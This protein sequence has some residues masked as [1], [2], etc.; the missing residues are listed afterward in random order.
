MIHDHPVD[1][2]D[3]IEV[4][5]LLFVGPAQVLRPTGTDNDPR[6]GRTYA[7]IAEAVAECPAGDAV[8]APVRRDVIVLDLDGCGDKLAA[9]IENEMVRMGGTVP[10]MARS[11]SPG[12]W[13][14]IAAF[15]K[16]E[17]TESVR[18]QLRSWAQWFNRDPLAYGGVD[19]PAARVEFK[20]RLRLP[21][22]PSFKADCHQVRPCDPASVVVEHLQRVGLPLAPPATAAPA[23]NH[24]VEADDL[25]GNRYPRPPR[26]DLAP[27]ELHWWRRAMSGADNGERSDIAAHLA[28]TLA[29]AGWAD[30]EAL[31][32]LRSV[33]LVTETW[34][35]RQL[36]V[37]WTRAVKFYAAI[38]ARHLAVVAGWEAHA[39]EWRTRPGH[40]LRHVLAAICH[41]RFLDGGGLE[42]RPLAIRDVAEWS[43]LDKMPVSRAL[44][45]LIA[46]DTL[47]L[48]QHHDDAGRTDATTYTL[49]PRSGEIET[50]ESHA[51]TPSAS[52]SGEIETRD[53]LH[54]SVS[55][56]EIDTPEYT[57]PGPSTHPRGRAAKKTRRTPTPSQRQS[58]PF[59]RRSDLPLHRCVPSGKCWTQRKVRRR[60]SSPSVSV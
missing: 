37:E 17:T 42:N 15:P 20:D 38:Y 29:A 41:H 55:S 40:Q 14:V 10:Y 57:P 12:S 43:G 28:R 27:T 56:G 59:G 1:M 35:E 44:T 36:I 52:P 2:I 6:P 50:R 51:S 48:V 39:A 4:A 53:D 60:K 7:T 32:R 30:E 8:V 33:E 5:E 45:N 23:A 11:G 3:C 34:S 46:E 9:D 16:P 25:P 58:I 31:A 19:N 13:H 54:V 49:V 18:G 21:G 24:Q 22:A 26:R 47:R